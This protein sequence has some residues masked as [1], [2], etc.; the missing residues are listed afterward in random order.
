[1][2]AVQ[3]SI[4]TLYNI[5]EMNHSRMTFWNDRAGQLISG[6][7]QP[8]ESAPWWPTRPEPSHEQNLIVAIFPWEA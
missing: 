5:S 1:M 2:F 3:P 4:Y 8:A 7:A 6:Y